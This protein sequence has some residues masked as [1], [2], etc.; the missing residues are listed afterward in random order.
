MCVSNNLYSVWINFIIHSKIYFCSS[1]FK[2]TSGKKHLLLNST[3]FIY[4]NIRKIKKKEEEEKSTTDDSIQFLFHIYIYT[5]VC[6]SEAMSHICA[7]T[8]DTWKPNLLKTLNASHTQPV[9]MILMP[10]L[11]L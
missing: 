5:Y 7:S 6:E 2:W 8:C 1:A 11:I 4:N 10:W 9:I 3:E